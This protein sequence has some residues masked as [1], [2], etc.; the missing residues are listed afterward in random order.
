MLWNI[1]R[2]QAIA[3]AGYHKVAQVLA[4][5]NISE[6]I[7]AFAVIHHYLQAT[8]EWVQERV[9]FFANAVAS[10]KSEV[11][12]LQ[13]YLR[14]EDHT[15]SSSL[16]RTTKKKLARYSPKRKQRSSTRK[17]FKTT[18]IPTSHSLVAAKTTGTISPATTITG[19]NIARTIRTT[20]TTTRITRT[21][22]ITRTT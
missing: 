8:Y 4:S 3:L 10:R 14:D 18:S 1:G 21:V 13:K 22:R 15:F 9:N 11:L 7:K 12:L 5:D 20:R 16:Y 17:P 2:N 6:A 19:K